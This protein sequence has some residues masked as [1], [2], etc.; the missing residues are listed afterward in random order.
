MKSRKFPWSP[1][2]RILE[3]FDKAI[4]AALGL[5]YGVLDLVS[6]SMTVYR[7]PLPVPGPT[8][9]PAALDFDDEQTKICVGNDE[10]RFS[11]LLRTIGSKPMP[12]TGVVA[13]EPI[14]QLLPE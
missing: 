11:I 2:T 13:S 8:R 10:I 4:L 6:N 5:F 3:K 12:W 9:N 1:V 14:R 7:N